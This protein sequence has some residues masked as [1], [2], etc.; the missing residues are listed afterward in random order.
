AAS[1]DRHAVSARYTVK[2]KADRDLDDYT[3]YLAREANLHVA[4][5][6]LSASHETFALLADNPNIGWLSR[7]KNP[8]LKNL[9][10]FRVSSFDKMLIL[11]RPLSEG[12][13]IL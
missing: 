10:I 1:K 2:P 7:L 12:V 13:D 5:G 3:D 4:L 8:A 9:R 6:F 11:Y